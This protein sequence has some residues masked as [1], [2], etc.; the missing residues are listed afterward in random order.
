MGDEEGM[1]NLEWLFPETVDFQCTDDNSFDMSDGLTNR[2]NKHSEKILVDDLDFISE[3]TSDL[4]NTFI[5]QVIDS[6]QDPQFG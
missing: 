5:Y 4:D 6:S 3:A 1:Y 2:N